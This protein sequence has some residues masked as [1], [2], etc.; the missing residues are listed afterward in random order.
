MSRTSP[1]QPIEGVRV[2]PQ[3][4]SG[5][6]LQRIK[7]LLGFDLLLDPKDY[8]SGLLIRNG[9]FEAPES[10][11]VSRLVRQGDTC[12]DAGSHIG[13]YTCLLAR[14]VGEAGRV[15]AFDA[16]PQACETANRNLSLNGLTCAEV[17]HTALSDH[18]GSLPFH[19]S[20]DE[21]TGLSSVGPI[22]TS[23]QTIQ[24]PCARL[25]TFLQNRG[26]EHI[27]LLKIDVEGSEEMVLRGLGRFLTS[28]ATD[29]ILV[30]LYDERLQVM[31]TC[32][33]KVKEILQNA[34]YR[35][36]TYDNAFGWQL[37]TEVHSR[38]DCNFLFVS[39]PIQEPVPP[40]SLAPVL[41][42]TQAAHGRQQEILQ[43]R[44]QEIHAL[45]LEAMAL[46]EETT[47][48][49]KR[50]LSVENSIGWRA[51]NVYRRFRD[52]LIPE[53]TFRRKL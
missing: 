26:I 34:G 3:N 40:F 46:Q 50:L 53:K 32:T 48:L 17:F 2:D 11:L 4:S 6:R 31:D 9:I 29:F 22:P 39:P 51:L 36:W 5:S 28:H 35:A 47:G 25:E 37:A 23:K 15:Y 49:Q 52:A 13:Y 20:S 8:F 33:E 24:V 7:T 30:E 42:Q 27:R 10:E 19:I 41:A 12:I 14:L 38:G 44:E 43:A 1:V 16:N 18:E 45:R 21:Q